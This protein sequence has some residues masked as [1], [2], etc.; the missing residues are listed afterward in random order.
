MELDDGLRT[1]PS[2]HL[3]SWN[4]TKGKDMDGT[5]KANKGMEY[6]RTSCQDKRPGGSHNFWSAFSLAAPVSA[7]TYRRGRKSKFL[8]DFDRMYWF[9]P[10]ILS[11]NI[12]F[13]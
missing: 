4:E 7:E 1:K 10:S 9:T 11:S 2:N 6:G 5:R 12:Y 8:I 13:R 3:T